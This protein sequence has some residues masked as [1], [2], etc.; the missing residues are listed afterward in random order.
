MKLFFRQRELEIASKISEYM[1][2]VVATGGGMVTVSD[3]IKLLRKNGIIIWL[4]VP[5]EGIMDRIKEDVSRPLAHGK[6]KKQL[7]AMFKIRSQLYDKCCD[8]SIDLSGKTIEQAASE[9][10]DFYGKTRINLFKKKEI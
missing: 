6:N 9:I 8:K 2:C 5:F 1:N 7:E 4:K 3:C 10:A